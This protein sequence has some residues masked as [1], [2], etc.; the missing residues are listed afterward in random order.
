MAHLASSNEKV[1]AYIA[2]GA[3]L[4]EREATLAAARGR[5]TELGSIVAISSL[6]E[7]EP[8]DYLDQPRFLNQVLALE[9]KRSP[10]G[11]LRALK[12]FERELGRRAGGPRNGPRDID[13]D[14]LLHG[15][16]LLDLPARPGWGALSLPHPRMH[17]RA[18]VL[19]PL[20]EIA[21]HLRHPVLGQTIA[22]LLDGADATGVRRI[23]Y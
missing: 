7:T 21:P 4:G 22:A 16:T 13:L 8:V 14:L 9:T 19:A 3:N 5:L 12:R 20:A 15:E 1:I 10:R 17:E 18:F 23:A 2:L 6:Y 11:L